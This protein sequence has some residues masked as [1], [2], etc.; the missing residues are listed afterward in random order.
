MS[1]DPPDSSGDSKSDSA[2]KDSHRARQ[3]FTTPL[4][5]FERPPEHIGPYRILEQIGEGGMGV[6][7][8]AEQEKP[9]R[10]RVARKK[11]PENCPT[12]EQ[13]F[14]LAFTT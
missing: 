14:P 11:R 12:G 10:R 5:K 13:L 3:R 6:V 8:L 9:I 1:Q 4:S 2:K 7:Y